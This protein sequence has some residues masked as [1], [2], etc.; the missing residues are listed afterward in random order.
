MKKCLII[1][2]FFFI[3]ISFHSNAQMLPASVLN[4]LDKSEKEMF[5]ATANGDS[6]A[7]KKIAGKDYFT[8]NADGTAQTLEEALPFIKR[9][10][11]SSSKLS[12]QKQRVF[13]NVVVRTGNAKFFF[14]GQPVAE[15][16]YTSGWIYRD[17][18]WQFIHWQGTATGMSLQGKGLAE[19]PNKIT[20]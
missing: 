18:R 19:P 3:Q 14:G 12:Q 17:K 9:F 1:L 16:L 4:L 13:G 15:V 2:L 20:D 8:I 10:K 7:F 11:G 6:A 5:D